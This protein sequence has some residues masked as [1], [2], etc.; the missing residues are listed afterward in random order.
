VEVAGEDLGAVEAGWSDNFALG[1]LVLGGVD[2][3]RVRLVDDFGNRPASSDPEALYVFDLEIAGASWIDLNGLAL[4]FRNSGAP[5]RLFYGDA[6]LDGQVN[7]Q[8]LSILATNWEA[9]PASWG[10][11]NCNGDD[12]VNVQD[13][14]L[15]ATNWGAGTAQPATVPQPLTA[16]L[17]VLAALPVVARGRGAHSLR[18]PAPQAPAG[19]TERSDITHRPADAVRLSPEPATA[20]AASNSRRE[21]PCQPV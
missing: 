8:D 6:N 18:A 15:L 3:G 1:A 21:R 5:K 12:V 9:S 19:R 7:V 14:S 2:A 13:L 17:L 20:A 10:Q 4:Y 11:A 16:V